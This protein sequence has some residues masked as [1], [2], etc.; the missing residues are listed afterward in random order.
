MGNIFLPPH[1]GFRPLLDNLGG[2]CDPA[3]EPARSLTQDNAEP[4]SVVT[5]STRRTGAQREF[6]MS[7]RDDR[8]YF[9]QRAEKERQ[10]AERC[11]DPAIAITHRRLA[12]EYERKIH[13]A[14]M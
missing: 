1:Q 2:E 10:M 6:E 8:T 11:P 14:D 7:P 9:T 13:E 3:I 12:W 4:N 5:V